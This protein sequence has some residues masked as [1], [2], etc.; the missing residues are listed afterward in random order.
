[1]DAV[2]E[3][4]DGRH[5][6]CVIVLSAFFAIS[7]YRRMRREQDRMVETKQTSNNQ[8]TCNGGGRRWQWKVAAIATAIAAAIAAAMARRRR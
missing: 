6:S 5:L 2:D 4:D 7:L 1:L 8:Q 3:D